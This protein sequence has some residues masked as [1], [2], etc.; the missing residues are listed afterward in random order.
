MLS[1]P[2]DGERTGPYPKSLSMFGI[3]VG[4]YSR[5]NRVSTWLSTWLSAPRE[6][7][8]WQHISLWYGESDIRLDTR[9]VS[10]S[11]AVTPL[12]TVQRANAEGCTMLKAAIHSMDL[13]WPFAL[14]GKGEER[15]TPQQPFR[16]KQSW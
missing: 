5:R 6:A 11:M 14:P 12:P 9:S 15:L 2:P 1:V 3:V 10:N 4:R 13:S 8:T 16:H 7:P